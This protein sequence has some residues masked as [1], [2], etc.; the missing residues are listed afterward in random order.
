MK[1]IW[2]ALLLLGALA[3]VGGCQEESERNKIGSTIDWGPGYYWN[4]STESVERN[5]FTD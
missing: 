3:L 4:S 2:I 1:K 5:P